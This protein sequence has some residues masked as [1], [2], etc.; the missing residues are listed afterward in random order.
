[1]GRRRGSTEGPA[2]PG[3]RSSS[4][5]SGGRSTAGGSRPTPS[6]PIARKRI[7]RVWHIKRSEVGEIDGASRRRGSLDCGLDRPVRRGYAPPHNPRMGWRGL[8]RRVSWH[9]S[10]GRRVG[11]F[12]EEIPHVVPRPPSRSPSPSLGARS[13]HPPVRAARRTAAHGRFGRRTRRR[14]PG[15]P[16]Q[17]RPLRLLGRPV[18][19]DRNRR[20]PGQRH[21]H[22]AGPGRGLRLDRADP[23][24]AQ[25]HDHAPGHGDDPRRVAAGGV[26]QLRPDRRPPAGDGRHGHARADALRHPLGRPAT[27]RDRGEHAGQG[28][29]RPG[30]RHVGHGD[31]PAPARRPRRDRAERHAHVHRR[32]T[33]CRGATRSTSPSRSRTRGKATP[34]PPG[35][36]SS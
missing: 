7:V 17:Y 30:R 14:R 35:P 21:D 8:G 16:V 12:M 28:R 27:R 20:Q 11:I 33:S 36:G 13:H 5:D 23:R 9:G 18:P 1:M 15:D 32:P 31:R 24:D 22:G 19:R 3:S 10:S 6:R 34:R 2:R 26:V 25:R 29:A 4:G